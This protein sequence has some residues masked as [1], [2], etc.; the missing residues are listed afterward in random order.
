MIY[1]ILNEI[2]I[3]LSILH[4][5]AGLAFIFARRGTVQK[6]EW[7]GL[8]PKKGSPNKLAHSKF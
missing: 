5:P 1:S 4:C 7:G 8:P 2:E 6:N 3:C